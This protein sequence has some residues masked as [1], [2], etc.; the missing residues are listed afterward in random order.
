[1]VLVLGIGRSLLATVVSPQLASLKKMSSLDPCKK[2]A[3]AVCQMTSTPNKSDNLSMATD[4]IDQSVKLGAKVSDI[5]FLLH[6]M[7]FC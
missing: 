4:L 3:V 2:A 5:R 6:S 7:W 1:M